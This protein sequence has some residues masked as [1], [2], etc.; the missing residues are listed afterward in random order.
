MA[1]NTTDPRI[2]S[3]RQNMAMVHVDFLKNLALQGFDIGKIDDRLLTEV[4]GAL[5]LTCSGD[6]KDYFGFDL[7][8]VGP[9]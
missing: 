8:E 6:P 7:I 2:L 4:V 9:F 1:D 5:R 3:I